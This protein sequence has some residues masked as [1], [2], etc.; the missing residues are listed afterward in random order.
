MDEPTRPN[1]APEADDDNTSI[2]VTPED[3]LAV[4]QDGDMQT[5]HGLMRYSSNYTFL[6]TMEKDAVCLPAI[7]KPRKGERP[8]WDFPE[9]TL[10]KRERASFLTS[11]LLGWSI[12][13]PTVVREGDHGVGSV[14]F[15]IDHDPEINYFSFDETHA[16][17]LARLSIFDALVNNADRKGG[18]CLLDSNGQIWGIDHGITFNEDHKLRTVIWDFAGERIP[19]MLLAD[20]QRLCGLLTDPASTYRQQMN[21]LL[22][23][24]EI[25]AFKQ[26]VDKLIARRKFPVPG[27]GPN[28]PWPAV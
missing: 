4:L 19:D 11:E 26:R 9:G 12:V 21:E 2:E 27:P 13:P 6:V 25:E 7:Y 10:Y 24:Y 5:M 20:V 1:D 18:H 15:Y 8:L 23:P 22:N 3:V 16:P 28:Y 14:Q 17:Q